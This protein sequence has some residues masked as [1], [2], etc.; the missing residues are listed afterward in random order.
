MVKYAPVTPAAIVD[1]VRRAGGRLWIDGDALCL[2]MPRG[3]LTKAL[4]AILREQKPGIVKLIAPRPAMTDAQATRYRVFETA[5]A[6][7]EVRGSPQP[8]PVFTLSGGPWPP[9]RCI[10]CGAPVTRGHRRCGDC[11][12]ALQHMLA[13]EAERLQG[14]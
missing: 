11:L 2:A 14:F 1:H 4:T 7:W 8:G 13:I 12:T 6:E 5:Y 10:S 3:L 9:G